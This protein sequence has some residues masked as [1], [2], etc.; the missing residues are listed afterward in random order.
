ML[1]GGLKR[2]RERLTTVENVAQIA[3]SKGLTNQGKKFGRK[4]S[5][6]SW[7]IISTIIICPN[8]PIFQNSSCTKY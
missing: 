8:I 4:A 2:E 6:V 3:K 7:P 5:E 1:A